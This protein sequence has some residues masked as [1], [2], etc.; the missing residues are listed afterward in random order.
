MEALDGG[1]RF[2]GRC[3]HYPLPLPLLQVSGQPLDSAPS[4][5]KREEGPAWDGRVF[6]PMSGQGGGVQGRGGAA[7]EG[8]MG[9]RGG[10]RVK[11]D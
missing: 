10:A 8:W 6:R 2:P 11:V 4:L 3:G 9:V 5:A 1:A 7:A